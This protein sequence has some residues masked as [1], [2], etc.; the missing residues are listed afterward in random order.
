MS[1][2][3]SDADAISTTLRSRPRQRTVGRDPLSLDDVITVVNVNRAVSNAD[4]YVVFPG[5]ITVGR[6]ERAFHE[7]ASKSHIQLMVDFKNQA[8]K[9]CVRDAYSVQNP[10][11]VARKGVPRAGSCAEF[12][13][14]FVKL[15]YAKC[16]LQRE[17]DFRRAYGKTDS[18]RNRRCDDGLS[19]PTS[20]NTLVCIPIGEGTSRN[21]DEQFA[22]VASED[23]L[24]ETAL[25]DI[26]GW[27]QRGRWDLDN[28]LMELCRSRDEVMSQDLQHEVESLT[29]QVNAMRL[30]LENA[31]GDVKRG[32]REVE[33]KRAALETEIA[34]GERTT[35]ELNRANDDLALVKVE[36]HASLEELSRLKGPVTVSNDLAILTVELA[37]E[38]ER[39]KLSE[40]TFAETREQVQDLGSQ[41][42][43][44]EL[45]LTLM[46]ERVQKVEM[47]YKQAAESLRKARDSRNGR[48][49]VDF[50]TL[51]DTERSPAVLRQKF[52]AL[53]RADLEVQRAV[54]EMNATAEGIAWKFRMK[55]FNLKNMQ[56]DNLKI[57]VYRGKKAMWPQK[58]QERWNQGGEASLTT[59]PGWIP[60]SEAEGGTPNL[61]VMWHRAQCYVCHNYF[62]PEGGYARIRFTFPA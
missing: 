56:G 20:N 9:E 12:S 30:Q 49:V 13:L 1:I 59:F 54:V 34:E 53:K 52:H 22:E 19:Q 57:I 3:D 36:L 26:I 60:L 46:G 16:V 61:P 38:Q 25:V 39:L 15:L 14:T 41:K 62:G 48:C 37:A 28:A 21:L 18:A 4:I 10:D 8:M 32:R 27:I 6:E 24:E 35:E 29:L 2:R 43:A 45:S 58:E 50:A 44:W 31:V 40:A 17:V 33:E 55:H 51:T 7:E 42:S 23:M 11:D 5:T 47:K